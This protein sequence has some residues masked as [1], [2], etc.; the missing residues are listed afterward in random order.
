MQS[1]PTLIFLW[2]PR[3]AAN[4]GVSIDLIA[5]VARPE[6]VLRAVRRYHRN[7]AIPDAR[8]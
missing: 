4:T 6:V 3:V 8:C 1:K 7:H 2:R 5:T